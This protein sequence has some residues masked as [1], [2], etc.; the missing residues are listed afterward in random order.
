MF[1]SM[2]AH[3]VPLSALETTHNVIS[4]TGS[5]A[6]LDMV[7]RAKRNLAGVYR[8][9]GTNRLRAHYGTMYAL[10]K[11]DGV[12]YMTDL[13]TVCAEGNYKFWK[14]PSVVEIQPGSGA[15]KSEDFGPG[16]DTHRI[17]SLVTM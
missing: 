5:I 13:N 12:N 4:I 10:Q 8:I 14:H 16:R 7:K 1:P 11:P 2:M 17:S 9:P 15:F 6:D 3:F